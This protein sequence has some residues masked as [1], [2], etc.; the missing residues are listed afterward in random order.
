MKS[1]QNS[2]NPLAENATATS[3]ATA[4]LLFDVREAAARLSISVVSVRKLIRQKRLKRVP[5]FRKVLIS[6]GEL[7]R[8]AEL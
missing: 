6:D 2:P 4:K 3:N 5:D 7:K 8:F 1:P